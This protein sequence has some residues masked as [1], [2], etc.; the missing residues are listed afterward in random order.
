[1][2]Q[3]MEVGEFV[4]M[5][6]HDEQVTQAGLAVLTNP[7]EPFCHF[8]LELTRNGLGAFGRR[9]R[10]PA[11]A[12]ELFSSQFGFRLRPEPSCWADRERA[13]PRS[14]AHTHFG[15][16]PSRPEPTL[17]PQ[18]LRAFPT[19]NPHVDGAGG[20]LLVFPEHPIAGRKVEIVILVP[21]R[22]ALERQRAYASQL[23]IDGTRAVTVQRRGVGAVDM[24]AERI[25]AR[26]REGYLRG[27]VWQSEVS[28]VQI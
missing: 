17:V 27:T 9:K 19:P 12:A 8:R 6:L 7:L 20:R 24:R 15:E 28:L 13:E 21:L 1:M 4:A 25:L 18:A 26:G 22:E 14:L 16:G 23:A 2:Q 5:G 3:K 10:V 11:F